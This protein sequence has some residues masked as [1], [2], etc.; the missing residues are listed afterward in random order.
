MSFEKNMD[1][2][3]WGGH[4]DILLRRQLTS[5][6]G[7]GGVGVAIGDFFFLL[8][9]GGLLLGGKILAGLAGERG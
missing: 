6:V 5:F 1:E 2:N 8:F 7:G 9:S 4:S 3:D